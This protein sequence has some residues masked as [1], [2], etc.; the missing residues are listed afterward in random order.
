MGSEN[1]SGKPWGTKMS[2]TYRD[3]K[4]PNNYMEMSEVRMSVNR[5]M[6]PKEA[7]TQIQKFLTTAQNGNYGPFRQQT[8]A[9]DRNHDNDNHESSVS[10]YEPPEPSEPKFPNF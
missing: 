8:Q 3:P 9:F 2:Y 6:D 7:E 1:S 5:L 10:H 4:N